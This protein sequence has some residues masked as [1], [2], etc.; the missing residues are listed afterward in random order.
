MLVLFIELDV[1]QGDSITQ[2]LIIKALEP[3]SLGVKPKI[4][5]VCFILSKVFGLIGWFS[6][7][8]FPLSSLPIL[9]GS[10]KD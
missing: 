1:H 5:K 3:D 10:Y 8:W 4:C 2:W 7:P 6:H 9:M